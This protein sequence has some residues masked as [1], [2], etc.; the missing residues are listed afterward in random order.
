MELNVYSFGSKYYFKDFRGGMEDWEYGNSP[1]ALL[2]R[3]YD[4]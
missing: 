3:V 1:H 4:K 2:V